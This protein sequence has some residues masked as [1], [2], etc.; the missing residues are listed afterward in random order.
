MGSVGAEGFGALV[1]S[2]WVTLW[3]L[4]H[5]SEQLG[6][7]VCKLKQGAVGGRTMGGRMPGICTSLARYCRRRRGLLP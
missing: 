6:E 5:W 3:V 4:K 7:L 1:G 2:G